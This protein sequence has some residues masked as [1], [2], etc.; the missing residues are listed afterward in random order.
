MATITLTNK[1]LRLIQNALDLYSR[2]GILQFDRILEHPDIDRIMYDKYTEKKE[3]EVGVHTTRGDIVEIGEDYIKTKGSW[4][5]GEEIKTWTDIENIKVSPDWEKYHQ[6]KEDCEFH[7]AYIK[8]FISNI[9]LGPG[10]R[11]SLGIHHE[12]TSSSRQAFDIIQVIRHEFWKENPTK[13]SMTV[14]SS[15]NL[16]SGDSPV[17]VKLDDIKD[18]RK[19]KLKNIKK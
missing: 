18:I 14:D 4:G 10:N 8:S 5:N 16:T 9:D 7:F 11:G 3:L 1:Q 2:I 13:S 17:K 12:N 19:Q 6:A 15:I